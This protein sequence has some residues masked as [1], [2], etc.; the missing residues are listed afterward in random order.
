MSAARAFTAVFLLVFVAPF[1]SAQ[2]DWLDSGL[3]LFEDFEKPLGNFIPV[4]APNAGLNQAGFLNNSKHLFEVEVNSKSYTVA[5]WFMGDMQSSLHPVVLQNGY[6]CGTY[7]SAHYYGY[8]NPHK[9]ALQVVTGL[10]CRSGLVFSSKNF[11]HGQFY[12]VAAVYDGDRVTTYINGETLDDLTLNPSLYPEYEIENFSMGGHQSRRE[13]TGAYDNFRVYNRPLSEGEVSEL[14]EFEFSPSGLVSRTA[15]DWSYDALVAYYKFDGNVED[16]SINA[17]NTRVSRPQWVSDRF[18]VET[19]ALYVDQEAGNFM[20]ASASDLPLRDTP[21]TISFWL[22][23][24][25]IKQDLG[26]PRSRGDIIGYGDINGDGGSVIASLSWMPNYAAQI[27]FG[28]ENFNWNSSIDPWELDSWHHL[29]WVYRGGNEAEIYVNGI[30]ADVWVANSTSKQP[31]DL[32]LNTV[33]RPLEV[34]RFEV[35]HYNGAMDDLRIYSRPLSEVEVVKLYAMEKPFPRTAKQSPVLHLPFEKNANDISGNEH[36]GTVHG[37]VLTEDR[38]GYPNSAYNFDGYDDVIIV[39]HNEN[40]DF[41]RSDFSLTAWFK[42]QSAGNNSFIVAKYSQFDFPG[43][44]MGVTY[45]EKG[46]GFL[47]DSNLENGTFQSVANTKLGDQDWHFMAVTFDRSDNLTIFI[48]GFKR[49]VESISTESHNVSNSHELYIGNL[50]PGRGFTGSID[51]IAIYDRA[52]TP[53]EI[54]DLR[55]APP[56]AITQQPTGNTVVQGGA[57]TLSVLVEGKGEFKYQWFKD[58]IEL[59]DETDQSMVLSGLQYQDA[60]SYYVKVSTNEGD[61]NSENAQ[62]IVEGSPQILKQPSSQQ[63]EVGQPIELTVEAVGTESFHYEWFLNG[64]PFSGASEQA[65][66][67]PEAVESLS[68][69]YHVV[70]KNQYGDIASESV[71][72]SVTFTDSDGD[73]VGNW[74]ELEMG[75]NPDLSDTDGDGLSDGDETLKQALIQHTHLFIEGDF[76]WKEANVDAMD[77][78]GYLAAVSSQAEQDQ[79]NHLMPDNRNV[80]IGGTDESGKWEWTTGEIFPNQVF[81]NWADGEP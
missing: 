35:G 19:S 40:L 65:L 52:L 32:A 56:F 71:K 47:A 60:G 4:K 78:G 14:Y 67:V 48:D 17:I 21:R 49:S 45:D 12:H 50:S 53:T 51:D 61:L 63:L 41:G 62:I 30:A 75:T 76:S 79:L 3:V 58:S 68:G 34:G 55:M 26:V 69:D 31:V 13:I 8:L 36:H 38:Y 29:V 72:V 77:R 24:N 74:R 27:S 9:N 22:K 43:Y 42:L 37:A 7:L 66:F 15:P 33:N 25:N 18:G 10:A 73:G 46:F 28:S 6:K 70:V 1:V 16:S 5:Y 11:N 57:F 23:P 64:S 2:P 39:P 81:S 80:W 59:P 44:G 20:R 54:R